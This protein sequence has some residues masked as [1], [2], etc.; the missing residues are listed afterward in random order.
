MSVAAAPATA[1]DLA[2]LV[3]EIWA[4]LVDVETEPLVP[5]A[6]VRATE[7]LTDRWS[8]QVVVDGDWRGIVRV[9]VAVPMAEAL[10][11]RMLGGTPGP[12]DLE[13]AVG[14]LANMI[15]GNVKSLVP[16]DG[17]L[18]L[19]AAGHPL[20][21]A[22]GVLVCRSDHQWAG[23]RLSVMVLTPHH[24]HGTEEAPR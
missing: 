7:P 13:D 14:E 19:P 5:V 12:A 21:T 10:A 15:G 24:P 9:D 4:S 16:G 23:H 3:E 22:R 2:A 8:G 11:A 17:T 1:E 20:P 18:S 6:D